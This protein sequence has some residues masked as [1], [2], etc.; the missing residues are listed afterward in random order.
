MLNVPG[1]G[2]F[3]AGMLEGAK[4]NKALESDL[5]KLVEVSATLANDTFKKA[6]DKVDQLNA[7]L[8]ALVQGFGPGDEAKLQ[9]A[10]A[11][12][13]HRHEKDYAAFEATGAA[14]TNVLTAAGPLLQS[15]K[16]L[17]FGLSLALGGSLELAPKALSTQAGQAALTQALEA[18]AAG[19]SSPLLDTL[20][21]AAQ[22][23]DGQK[24]RDQL[25]PVLTQALGTAIAQ[26]KSEGRNDEAH[27]LI[28]SLSKNADLY[29]VDPSKLGA[30]QTALHH[31]LDN[32]PD[33]VAEVNLAL[34]GLGPFIPKEGAT[35]NAFGA[36][37]FV[38]GVAGLGDTFAGFSD[39][40]VQDQ[41][42]AIASTL[43]LGA[44]GAGIAVK[45]FGNPETQEALGAL[46]GKASATTGIIGAVVGVIDFAQTLSTGSIGD[47]AVSGLNAASGILL[48]IPGGQI[49]G[50]GLAIASFA[51]NEI[52][53]QRRQQEAEHAS[54]KDAKAFLIAA[55][56]DEAFASV[57]ANLDNEK[58]NI[59]AFVEQ[60][61]QKLGLT[62]DEL[63]AKLNAS[64]GKDREKLLKLFKGVSV[65]AEV[66]GSIGEGWNFPI[67][68]PPL[69]VED[70]KDL[71]FP[72]KEKEKIV[73]AVNA[74]RDLMA[75]QVA[76]QV[77]PLID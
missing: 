36:L 43:G 52:L 58:K 64:T 16:G 37:G 19:Q 35:A 26:L 63:F 60:V 10:V 51:L 27:A 13:K 4:G 76:D 21:R 77:G 32:K 11:A 23:K 40:Q 39:K 55:G 53:G 28:D 74:Q 9:A 18:Q 59:G 54:E 67:F 20:T 33:A 2:D 29:G 65:T 24:L 25:A 45:V 70:L 61:A 30:F 49:A 68:G 1:S 62:R 44:G 31:A 73:K 42:G 5:K 12:F 75:Q 34:T 8:N 71:P 46:F 47:V 38:V 14:L 57:F 15:G 17:S 50:V 69:T 48:L 41:V 3:V 72:K 56:L 66:L 22:G 6:S 7:E